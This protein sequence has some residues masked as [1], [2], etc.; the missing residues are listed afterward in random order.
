[1]LRLGLKRLS[2]KLDQWV[3]CAAGNLTQIVMLN[4]TLNC[5][6]ANIGICL[7]CTNVWKNIKR[8]SPRNNSFLW[9]FPY[10]LSCYSRCIFLNKTVKRDLY[11]IC[12][13]NRIGKLDK[14]IYV[15]LHRYVCMHRFIET[16]T[17]DVANER[18]T[19]TRC[20]FCPTKIMY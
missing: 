4:C 10:F 18:N 16:I 3:V 9:T 17:T 2:L 19:S 11:L 15:Y 5:L 1:M 20:S 6:M 14:C 12:D 8:I 7:I 13:L